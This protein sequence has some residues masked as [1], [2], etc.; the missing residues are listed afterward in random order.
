MPCLHLRYRHRQRQGTRPV[1]DSKRGLHGLPPWRQPHAEERSHRQAPVRGGLLPGGGVFRQR[2]P[3]QLHLPLLRPRPSRQHPPGDQGNWKLQGNCHPDDG[4][5]PL[6]RAVLQWKHGQQR[7]ALQ[8][9]RQG[10]GPN[11]RT[12]HLRLR[13][14]AVRPRHRTMGQDGPAM[15]EIL[16]HEPVCVLRGE[17]REVCGS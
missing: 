2:Q 17:S 7:A 9:Q 12:G 4:L 13:C 15:R 1:G 16:Q 3:G 11:A 10:A 5:L 14:T 6:R 8:V